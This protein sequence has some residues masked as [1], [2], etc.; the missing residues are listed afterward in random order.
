MSTIPEEIIIRSIRKTATPEEQEILNRWL[1]ED[2]KN[3]EY[4]F[5]LEEIGYFGKKLPERIINKGWERLSTAIEI[6]PQRQTITPLPQKSKTIIWLR[7]I[8]AVFIGVL[9]ASAIWMNL[10]SEE[11]V[12]EL[13]VQNVVYNRTGVQPVLL[14]DG[15]EVW[16]NE[17]TRM[18]YPEQFG[19]EKRSVSLE[20]KAYFDIRKDP[21]KPFIVQ[22]GNVEIEVTGT[23]FFVE[24]ALEDT[25]LITL[26]S[27]SVN[28]NY[29]NPEGKSRSVSL[30]PGQ[31]AYIN[32]LDGEADITDVDTYYYVAWKDGTYRFQNE[33][34]D[35]ITGLLAKRLDLDIRIISPSLR[36]KRFTGRITQN[37]DIIEVMKTISK[38]YPVSYRIKGKTVEISAL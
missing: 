8:A 28:L 35:K 7:Y 6:Q 26:I 17:N 36:N 31:Q 25:S 22:I 23:E 18:I 16:I 1:K 13:L 33:P 30:I 15:S 12:Q 27:G 19:K 5:Q 34:L 4:Y 21:D 24:A 20:G 2:R 9:I 29:K 38:S 11:K 14:S 3:R 32:R 10:P 37:D